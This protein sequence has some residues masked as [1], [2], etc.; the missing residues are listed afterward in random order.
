MKD[1]I[2]SINWKKFL[3]VELW[4]IVILLLLYIA[5]PNKF[6]HNFYAV[7]TI[8]VLFSVMVLLKAHLNYSERK[9]GIRWKE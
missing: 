2:N 7:P 9:N 4:T 1:F 3:R 5:S 6:P 8:F